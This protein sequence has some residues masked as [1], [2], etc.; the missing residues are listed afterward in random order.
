MLLALLAF[1]PVALAIFAGPPPIPESLPTLDAVR[2]LFTTRDDGTALVGFLIWVGWFAWATFAV[3]VLLEIPAAVRGRAAVRV[4]GLR[5][6]QRAAAGL[7]GLIILA[8]TAGPVATAGVMTETVV[9]SAPADTSASAP[10]SFASPPTTTST[11]TDDDSYV[12]QPGDTLWEIAERELGS[13]QR[14]PEIAK[15][16]YGQPQPNDPQ[17]LRDPSSIDPGWQLAI[18]FDTA[19]VGSDEDADAGH[20]VVEGDTLWDIAAASLGPGAT[21]AD[22]A[23]EWPRWYER[24]RDLIGD[25]PD[26]IQPGMQLV[27]PDAVVAS[28]EKDDDAASDPRPSPKQEPAAEPDPEPEPDENIFDPMPE[29][30]PEPEPDEAEEP[31]AEE[32]DSD[33]SLTVVD[34]RADADATDMPDIPIR[35]IGGIGSLLAAGLVAVFAVQR[36]RRRSKRLA[37]ESIV[38]DENLLRSEQALWDV[39][40]QFGVD[41]V[42]LGLRAIAASC[43][44][45]GVRL[46]VVR[47]ARLTA[48]QF[49]LYLDEPAALPSPWTQADDDYVWAIAPGA[50]LDDSLS[51]AEVRDTPAPYPGL[52]TIGH[53]V[54]NGHILLDL[55]YV[56]LL[57]VA[58]S[59]LR[60]RHVLTALAIELA[61]SSWADDA[62]VAVVGIC[63]ELASSLGTGRPRGA[64]I[65]WGRVG[66]VSPVVGCGGVV[67]G[68]RADRDSVVGRGV[69]AFGVVALG[70]TPPG[71]GRRRAGR[72][73]G[74]CVGRCD[75]SGGVA[76]LDD[77]A[78]PDRSGTGRAGTSRSGCC[79]AAGERHRLSRHRRH[80]G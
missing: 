40:D 4:P 78:R 74:W 67:P 27:S 62:T 55:E 43:A 36:R 51:A 9:V 20:I 11:A 45:D 19:D 34:A 6:Q 80:A 16:N 3:S 72:C 54:E 28:Q 50:A 52:V 59:E 12:V 66:C 7:I 15:L 25:N 56:G 13:G 57:A 71:D 23:A 2:D 47:A 39:A 63:S 58:G 26:L 73:V 53:D 76:G 61:T 35:T 30:L 68:N 75:G 38:I 5:L 48:D 37:G 77:H 46:P 65:V 64:L 14:W 10:S 70:R 31:A 41:A 79:A 18:P 69:A 22:I 29:P 32:E 44:R 49:E 1:P 21:N 24:N 33:S 8:V 42:D 60:V 17:G